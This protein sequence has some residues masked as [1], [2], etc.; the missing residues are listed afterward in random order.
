MSNFDAYFFKM[1]QSTEDMLMDIADI[2]P[3]HTF[4][5]PQHEQ[6]PLDHPLMNR[7]ETREAALELAMQRVFDIT[8]IDYLV[9]DCSTDASDL[10]M[11]LKFAER[12]DQIAISLKGLSDDCVKAAEEIRGKVQDAEDRKL[13]AIGIMEISKRVELFTDKDPIVQTRPGP[14]KPFVKTRD[15]PVKCEIT[16]IVVIDS[17]EDEIDLTDWQKKTTHV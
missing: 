11:N 15:M 16:D 2:T 1:D 12:L 14:A 8:Q 13:A 10:R 6:P 4:I 3:S 9:S 5:P 7:L 17:E